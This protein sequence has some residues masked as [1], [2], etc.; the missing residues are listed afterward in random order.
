MI[1]ERK[2]ARP[3]SKEVDVIGCIPFHDANKVF[4]VLES[5]FACPADGESI[6]SQRSVGEH[7]TG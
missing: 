1:H 4:G 5:Q 3:N 2:N 6:H 7:S